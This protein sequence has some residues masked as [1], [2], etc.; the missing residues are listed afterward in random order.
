MLNQLQSQKLQ[1]KI[2]PHHIA[3]LNLLHLDSMSLEQRI[4]DEISDNPALEESDSMDELNGDKFSK[5]TVQDFQNWDEYGYDDIPDYKMEYENYLPADK[6][7]DRQLAEV[8]DFRMDLK[9]QFRFNETSQDKYRLAD[10]LIDSLN[11]DGFLLQDLESVAEEI[12]FTNNTW[13]KAE[14]LERIL[15]SIQ[16]LDPVGVGWR[17]IKEYF[18]IQLKR[19]KMSREV[20]LANELLK[21]HYSD[22]HTCNIDKIRRDMK[23]KE[24]EFRDTLQ[25]LSTLKT[26]P[27]IGSSATLQ[28]NNTVFPEFIITV[29][30]DELHVALARQR[31]SSLHV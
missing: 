10:F 30:A 3:L 13:V 6:M 18:L 11:E 1:H 16:E 21:N 19:M 24:D 4:E 2:L 14:E 12:S 28:P 29:E 7:P 27:V 26:R 20:E 31:S 5:D 25:L 23:L 22:L 17:D 8:V 15:F 9:K